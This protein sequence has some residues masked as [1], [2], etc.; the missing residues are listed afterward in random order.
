MPTAYVSGY[1]SKDGLFSFEPHLVM[2][3]AGAALEVGKAVMLSVASDSVFEVLPLTTAL[4][5][6]FFGIYEGV[7]GSGAAPSI[8][9]LSGRAAV[10]GDTVSITVRGPAKVLAYDTSANAPAAGDALGFAVTAAIATKVTAL[11]AGHCARV[12]AREA[13]ASTSTAGATTDVFILY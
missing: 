9:G 3:R 4:D 8:S 13:Q 11:L 6:A 2:M 5:H 10:T 7:G 1:D 12:I